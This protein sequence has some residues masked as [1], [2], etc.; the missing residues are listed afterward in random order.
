ML[1]T[2]LCHGGRYTRS[3]NTCWR[4][5]TYASD[6]R[7]VRSNYFV[8]YTVF[9]G[10]TTKAGC[11]TRADK[12]RSALATWTCA[13]YVARATTGSRCCSTSRSWPYQCG[14]TSSPYSRCFSTS[15]ATH[16]E[17]CVAW[18]SY[19]DGHIYSTAS[20]RASF[21]SRPTGFAVTHTCS[22]TFSTYSRYAQWASTS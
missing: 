1:A 13:T 2:S 6:S 4:C 17:G 20:S 12:H 3:S 9:C 7:H 8:G 10:C 22:A 14:R 5:T 21:L 19:Q 16:S 15:R 11:H 18:S